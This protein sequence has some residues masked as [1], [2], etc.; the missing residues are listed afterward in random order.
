M[1]ASKDAISALFC[2]SKTPNSSCILLNNAGASEL[3]KAS[4]GVTIFVLINAS[5]IG[6][7]VVNVLC[8]VL[9]VVLIREVYTFDGI[10]LLLREVLIFC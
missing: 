10:A 9:K 5:G 1:S 3:N 8:I 4:K 2:V 6:A 7:P